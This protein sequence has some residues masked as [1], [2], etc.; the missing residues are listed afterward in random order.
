MLTDPV[1]LYL[2]AYKISTRKTTILDRK[3]EILGIDR[4]LK[5]KRKLRKLWQ[6]TRDPASKTAIN[7]VTRN[8]SRMVRKIAI[9][10]WEAKLVNCEVTTQAI[11]L[12]QNPSQKGVDQRHH[13]QFMVP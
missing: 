8:I 6:E 13:L 5:H 4:S 1:K 7:W 3:Y 9:E 12:L 2:Q 11:W 10:R